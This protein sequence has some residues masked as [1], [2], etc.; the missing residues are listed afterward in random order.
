MDTERKVRAGHRGKQVVRL[1]WDTYHK[2]RDTDRKVRAGHRGKQVAR[3]GWDTD[4]IS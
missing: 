1:G 4:H 2:A 3:L